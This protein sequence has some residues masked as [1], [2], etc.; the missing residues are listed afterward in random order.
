LAAKGLNNWLYIN[1][2]ALSGGWV[3]WQ[4]GGI[5]TYYAPA[6]AQTPDGVLF[7]V[8]DTNGHT[9]VSRTIL[10][11]AGGPWYDIGGIATAGPALALCGNSPYIFAAV[12]GQNGHIYINQQSL[13]N[14]G[15]PWVGWGD[16]GF[17]SP[18]APAVATTPDGVLIFAVGANGHTYFSRIVL[19]QAGQPWVDIGG[20]SNASPGAALCGNNPYI[21]AA[22][23]GMDSTVYINQAG[24]GGGWV[25]WQ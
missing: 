18:Y 25:G 20:V 5:Q 15:S 1:Q 3:G 23:K 6:V 2:G 17:Y 4:F 11:G 12:R 13:A 22:V 7:S 8:V 19:G 9:R 24:L 21:F 10:G 16:T 14:I